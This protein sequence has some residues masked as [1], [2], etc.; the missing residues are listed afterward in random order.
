[1]SAQDLKTFL[2]KAQPLRRSRG[3]TPGN[4]R[5]LG[6]GTAGASRNAAASATK[7]CGRRHGALR[8][9]VRSVAGAGAERCGIRY[10]TLRV[11][12]RSVAASGTERCGI[13]YGTLRY[14]VRNAAG[15]GTERCGIRYGALRHQARSVAATGTERCGCRYGA[16]RCRVRSAAGPKRKVAG[17]GRKIA[18]PKRKVAGPGR[19]IAGPGRKIAGPRRKIAGPR[20]CAKGSRWLRPGFALGQWPLFAPG[21][22]LGY[23]AAM[24][25]P[26]QPAESQRRVVKIEVTKLFNQFNH[27]IEL[28]PERVTVLHGPN[29][30]GK[31]KL[32][33]MV[34]W[35]LGTDEDLMKL[36]KVPFE[37]LTLTFSD[38]TTLEA[39]GGVA[40]VRE[41]VML[42]LQNGKIGLLDR[43]TWRRD[44][45]ANQ[46]YVGITADLGR[47][48]L[49]L[50]YSTDSF[51]I[52]TQRLLASD[53]NQ[54][55]GETA[56]LLTIRLVAFV[57]M[58][59][60][61]S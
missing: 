48:A 34:S 59:S 11:Q 51:L 60:R 31:T 57:Y 26:S 20:R 17:P 47:E 55:D 8:C 58:P 7:R 33:E 45:F 54:H 38:E 30:V 32:L 28:K 56:G 53:Q 6:P 42:R 43:G 52:P 29:G 36:A 37:R 12:A 50:R 24:S 61:I 15:A 23:A 3:A 19:K 5:Q 4:R 35:L 46:Y 22:Q 41:A 21:D 16:L 25:E 14:H 27:V 13:T 49:E 2:R 39:I 1:M 44:S 40:P 10:G 9:P 18:G